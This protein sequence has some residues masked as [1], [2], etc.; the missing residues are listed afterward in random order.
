[1]CTHTA[2]WCKA[3]R[4]P[5]GFG[6]CLHIHPHVWCVKGQAC[7]HLWG[8]KVA[9]T[10]CSDTCPLGIGN[11]HTWSQSVG[12]RAT[13]GGKDLHLIFPPEAGEAPVSGLRSSP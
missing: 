3:T 7:A 6:V 12:D 13:Q 11:S 5:I 1:M 2:H 8:D 9:G 10:Q 4:T